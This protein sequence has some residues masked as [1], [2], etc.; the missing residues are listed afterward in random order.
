MDTA[1]LLRHI[2]NLQ[3][4]NRE[5]VSEANREVAAAVA[6]FNELVRMLD[7]SPVWLIEMDTP[8]DDERVCRDA[9][10]LCP[11]ALTPADVAAMTPEHV[12]RVIPRL[13]EYLRTEECFG[14]TNQLCAILECRGAE[15]LSFPQLR[16]TW[17][18]IRALLESLMECDAT[19]CEHESVSGALQLMES[20]AI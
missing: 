16:L 12:S 5:L 7:G 14:A 6:V 1:T 4:A 10:N 15:L 8:R 11:L 9:T 3:R 20:L 18:R 17:R 13:C 2:V 19:A